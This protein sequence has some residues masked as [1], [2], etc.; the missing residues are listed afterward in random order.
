M[1]ESK[2]LAIGDTHGRT[3]WRVLLE[4]DL[5]QYKRI[6]FIGDYFDTHDDITQQQQIDNFQD[7]IFFKKKYLD[8]VILLIGNHDYHYMGDFSITYSGFISANAF[9]V[10]ELLQQALKES[11]IQMSHLEVTKQIPILFTHAGVTKTW[12][13]KNG[14]LDSLDNISNRINDLFIYTPK[15]FEFTAGPKYNNYGDEICQTPIWIRPHS[16]LA[17]TVSKDILQV[18]G[19]TQMKEITPI[20]RCVFIDVLGSKKE[21]FLSLEL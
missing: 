20:D 2:I 8:K 21:E 19:H 3:D 4:Q 18:V 13:L 15:V 14:E 11:L 12:W 10:R 17:D 6:V 9:T 7:I 1:K 16:L 5:S